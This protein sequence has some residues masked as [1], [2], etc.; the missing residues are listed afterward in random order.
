M[1]DGGVE[2]EGSSE[3][4]QRTGRVKWSDSRR[5]VVDYSAG[6]GG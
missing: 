5:V 2:R 3:E 1:N 4:A 6:G